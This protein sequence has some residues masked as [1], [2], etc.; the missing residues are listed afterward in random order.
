MGITKRD[1]E[2]AAAEHKARLNGPK[3]EDC[4]G[5]VYLMREFGNRIA[6]H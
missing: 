6:F 5:L 3:S 1:L 2:Q 4:F